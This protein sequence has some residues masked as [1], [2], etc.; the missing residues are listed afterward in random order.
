MALSGVKKAGANFIEA[1]AG[2]H[3]FPFKGYETNS[4]PL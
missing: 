4:V 1:G 2:M 3:S